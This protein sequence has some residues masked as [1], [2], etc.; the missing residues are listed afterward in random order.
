MELVPVK[1][2]KLAL[3]SGSPGGNLAYRDAADDLHGGFVPG[4]SVVMRM[5]EATVRQVAD[6]PM[7]VLLIGEPGTGKAALA[8]ELHRARTVRLGTFSRIDAS[9]LDSH[10]QWLHPGCHPGNEASSVINAGTLLLEEISDLPLSLQARMTEVVAALGA[11]T[12]TMGGLPRLV[13]TSTKDLS[14]EVQAGRLREDL[15][16][17]LGG[18]SLRLAPLR[19]RRADIPVLTEYFLD[20]CAA[21]LNQPKP[22]LSDAMQRFLLEYPWPKNIDELRETVR[23]IVAVGDEALALA[24]LRSRAQEVQR[25]GGLPKFISL[26]LA[27]RS[28]SRNAERELMLKVLSRTNWNRKHTAQ[29][30][31]ISYKALLYKLKQNGLHTSPVVDGGEGK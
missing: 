1:S 29:Q 28:A 11:T 2:R 15:Y 5:I 13:V 16:H 26:K 4:V 19:F 24:A 22:V 23:V 14:G 9:N 18:V 8:R 27:A 10:L 25:E 20:D 31:Q 30:L 7:P 12:G 21:A 6:L 3:G 17:L